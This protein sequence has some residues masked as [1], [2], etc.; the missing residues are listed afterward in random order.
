MDTLTGSGYMFDADDESALGN[1]G[2]A[3]DMDG[4][5]NCYLLLI[6]YQK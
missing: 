6:Q 4:Y 1:M 3:A 2:K 5:W